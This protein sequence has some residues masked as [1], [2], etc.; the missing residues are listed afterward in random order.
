MQVSIPKSIGLSR[1]IRPHVICN[2]Q[3]NKTSS[4]LN[5]IIKKLKLDDNDIESLKN[6]LSD[7]IKGCKTIFTDSTLSIG[8]KI[9][10]SEL[11]DI[12][13]EWIKI[14]KICECCNYPEFDKKSNLCMACGYSKNIS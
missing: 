5:L 12:I 6:Y 10:D 2:H 11:D 8:K 3:K 7:N 14:N 13:E 1:Y 4:N 9:S